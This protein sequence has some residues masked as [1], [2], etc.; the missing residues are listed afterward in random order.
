[1][2]MAPVDNHCC[3]GCSGLLAMSAG[4]REAAPVVG[5]VGWFFFDHIMHR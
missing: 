2:C 5:V 1:M 3:R 4:T